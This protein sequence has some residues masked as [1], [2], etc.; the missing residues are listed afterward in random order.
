[1]LYTLFPGE[2][3]FWAKKLRELRHRDTLVLRE[4][5]IFFD[6]KQKKLWELR[7]RNTLV[8]REKDTF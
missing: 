2:D 4:T 7:R 5:Y 1:M 8:L 3:T 6:R